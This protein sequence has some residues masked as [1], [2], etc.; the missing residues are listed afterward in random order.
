MSE[1]KRKQ[2]IALSIKCRTVNT[3]HSVRRGWL[4]LLACS[5]AASSKI[6]PK[7]DISFFKKKNI[8]YEI[9][10]VEQI[11]MPFGFFSFFCICF[12]SNEN[13]FFL[14]KNMSC[15]LRFSAAVSIVNVASLGSTRILKLY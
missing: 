5:Q 3:Y 9:F 13:F 10:Y 7:L 1:T 14:Y 8:S 4:V 15:T 11:A 12:V 6:V 2:K